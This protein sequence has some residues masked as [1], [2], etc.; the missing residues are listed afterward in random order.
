MNNQF[1]G[2]GANFLE[3]LSSNGVYD[4]YGGV[5][6]EIIGTLTISSVPEPSTI[7]LLGNG[8]LG[9]LGMIR[10]RRQTT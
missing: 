10:L 2:A 7:L 5:A 3:S 4:A 1:T 8:L 6:G 9:F